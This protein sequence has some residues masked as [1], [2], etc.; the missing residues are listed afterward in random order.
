MEGTLIYAVCWQ[1]SKTADGSVSRERSSVLRKLLALSCVE[2][3]GLGTGWMPGGR[4]QDSRD[5][6][7]IPAAEAMDSFQVSP[8]QLLLNCI[9]PSLSAVLPVFSSGYLYVIW[10]SGVNLL[11][12][13]SNTWHMGQFLCHYHP[14]AVWLFKWTAKKSKFILPKWGHLILGSLVRNKVSLSCVCSRKQRQM[15]T[16]LDLQGWD[17]SMHLHIVFCCL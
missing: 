16:M 13:E 8:W 12:L 14:R 4:H 5:I 9:Y 1:S 11:L 6:Q 17:K 2:R 3:V 15:K 10:I 7:T